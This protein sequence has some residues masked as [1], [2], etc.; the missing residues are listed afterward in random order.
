MKKKTYPSQ[1]TW[2]S[3]CLGE[4]SS[5][6]ELYNNVTLC[7]KDKVTLHEAQIT[8]KSV[9][10]DNFQ[11]LYTYVDILILIFYISGNL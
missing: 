8:L 3:Q 7:L 1:W 4:C 6:D 2:Q 10:Y 9:S 11:K 5:E